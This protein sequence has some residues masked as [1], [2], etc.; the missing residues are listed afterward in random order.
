MAVEA[1]RVFVYGGKGALGAACVSLFKSKKWVSL[2]TNICVYRYS[3]KRCDTIILSK[4][5]KML[6]FN[7]TK[8]QPLV[9]IL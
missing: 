4:I 6:T 2:F 3:F 1:G 5:N 9:G 8:P 7:A